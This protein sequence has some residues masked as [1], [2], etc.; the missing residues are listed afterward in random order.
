MRQST[1]ENSNK[2]RRTSWEVEADAVGA[3]LSWSCAHVQRT[4]RPVTDNADSADPAN[5]ADTFTS[6][7][8]QRIAAET[9]EILENDL[10][11]LDHEGFADQHDAA[12]MPEPVT[13]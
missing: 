3:E 4:R 1:Y 7:D 13:V 12:Q 8:G 2:E 6:P 11:Y 5:T 10:S 9:G